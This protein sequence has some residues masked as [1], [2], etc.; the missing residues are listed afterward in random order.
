MIAI[1]DITSLCQRK[2]QYQLKFQNYTDECVTLRIKEESRDIKMQA[3]KIH[4]NCISTFHVR[5]SVQAHTILQ[6]IGFV[7]LKKRPN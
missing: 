2:M 1:K 4:G 7:F 3:N 6:I 5:F